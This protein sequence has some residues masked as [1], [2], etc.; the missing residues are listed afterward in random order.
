MMD[1]KECQEEHRK[2]WNW[3]ADKTLEWRMPVSKGDYFDVK[4]EF[5]HILNFCFACE[6]AEEMLDGNEG[7]HRCEFCPIEWDDFCPDY[8][9]EGMYSPYA[10]WRELRSV[11]SVRMERGETC[12][13]DAIKELSTLARQVAE[14]P[15]KEVVA[16]AESV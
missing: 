8:M 5:D 12:E 11:I 1:I 3:I 4:T 16:D 10:D 9:C 6:Y 2:L 7:H 15:F 14:L 13:S